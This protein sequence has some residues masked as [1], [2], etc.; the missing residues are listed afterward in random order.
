MFAPKWGSV[1]V[2][3]CQGI[4]MWLLRSSSWFLGV[5]F[6]YGVKQEPDLLVCICGSGSGTNYMLEFHSRS[7]GLF[8][9]LVPA[10]SNY[11][12][13]SLRK[14]EKSKLINHGII[15]TVLLFL[16]NLCK[17]QHCTTIIWLF[18]VSCGLAYRL[19]QSSGQW[20]YRHVEFRWALSHFSVC[21]RKQGLK[22][23]AG[24]LFRMRC[25]FV[26]DQTLFIKGAGTCF[27]EYVLCKTD[28]GDLWFWPDYSCVCEI[29]KG[30]N[31]AVHMK[32]CHEPHRSQKKMPGLTGWF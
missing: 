7:S 12:D 18:P 6:L 29:E 32:S 5:F 24:M 3:G 28:V 23:A 4:A 13:A 25:L 11:S 8:K 16:Q 15:V 26:L 22:S 17:R 14:Q 1:V 30:V 31:S 10:M 2:G 27:H 9:L 19:T 21:M 20:W